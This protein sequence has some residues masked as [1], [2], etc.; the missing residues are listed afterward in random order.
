MTDI[1]YFRLTGSDESLITHTAFHFG[2]V[3]LSSFFF[4]SSSDDLLRR[5]LIT[6]IKMKYE[7]QYLESRSSCTNTK[8]DG[9]NEQNISPNLF[10]LKSSDE[11]R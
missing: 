6:R 9:K 11:I 3:S 5:I 4:S 1:R 7:I 2:V 8:S 10:R